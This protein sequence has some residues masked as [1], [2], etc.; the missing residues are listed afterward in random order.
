MTGRG[1]AGRSLRQIDDCGDA[2][3]FRGLCEIDGRVDKPGLDWIDQVS[4]IHAFHGLADFVDRMEITRHDFG[5][6]L[7]QRRRPIVLA[8]H[9]GADIEPTFDR[10][11]NGGA[12]GVSGRAGDRYFAVYVCVPRSARCR[13]IWF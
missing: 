8:M 7:F 10:F 13:S 4:R 2:C 1:A 12:A 9:H 5:T 6:Q 3:F 11:L